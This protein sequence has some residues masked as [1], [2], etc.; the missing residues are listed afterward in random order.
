LHT[1]YKFV[2]VSISNAAIPAREVLQHD[3]SGYLYTFL[4]LILGV[5]GLPIKKRVVAVITGICLFI[6]ADYFM[7]G[8]WIPHLKPS[9]L[10]L[11]SMAVT[12]GYVVVV[13]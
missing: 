2:V 3:G 1:A 7:L 6:F 12:Y 5:P 4:I 10:T 11:A 8:I 13:H 9:R